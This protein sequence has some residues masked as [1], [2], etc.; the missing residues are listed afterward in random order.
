[1]TEVD[2]KILGKLNEI[3]DL[4]KSKHEDTKV[5]TKVETKVENKVETKVETKDEVKHEVNPEVKCPMRKIIPEKEF[6]EY[7]TK[8]ICLGESLLKKIANEEEEFKMDTNVYKYK[9]DS[10]EVGNAFL[11]LIIFILFVFTLITF[12]RSFYSN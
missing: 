4:L 1:M 6:N 12:V 10:L 9:N 11:T 7:C 2:F 3:T 5:D 8:D